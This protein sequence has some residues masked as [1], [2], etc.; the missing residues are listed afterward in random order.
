MPS[1]SFQRIT[2]NGDGEGTWSNNP[3]QSDVM[4]VRIKGSNTAEDFAQWRKQ[5]QTAKQDIVLV[6]IGGRLQDD[7][8][9]LFDACDSFIV[10]SNSEDM[11]KSEF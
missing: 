6:D 2:A 9:P 11:I 10:V 5:I 3:N 1:E 7:K 8:G 4:A